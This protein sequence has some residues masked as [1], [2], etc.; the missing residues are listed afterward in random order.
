MLFAIEPGDTVCFCYSGCLVRG[1]LSF[2]FFFSMIG[3]DWAHGKLNRQLSF[4]INVLR[5]VTPIL[6]ARDQSK[7]L[8]LSPSTQHVRS[9][10]VTVSKRW[11]PHCSHC[12]NIVPWLHDAVSN[13]ISAKSF[14]GLFSAPGKE[15]PVLQCSGL[16]GSP[17]MP[18]PSS[19][20][21]L[22][23][24]RVTALTPFLSP[25]SESRRPNSSR[26][27]PRDTCSAVLG[28]GH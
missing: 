3:S 10:W 17:S 16:L 2:L 26:I 14:L 7:L 12:Q 20:C 18:P 27:W 1:F 8:A 28:Q 5:I 4:P 9:F 13:W 25:S 23:D 19:L 21:L 22:E 11:K 24:P 15:Q 6:G